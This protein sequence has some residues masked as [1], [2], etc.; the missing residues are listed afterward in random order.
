MHVEVSAFLAHQ[1]SKPLGDH[2][3]LY[4]A[5]KCTPIQAQEGPIHRAAEMTKTIHAGVPGTTTA[6]P[7]V[8][9]VCQSVVLNNDDIVKRGSYVV[10]RTPR[11]PS[12]TREQVPLAPA[13]EVGHVEEILADHEHG[14]LVGVLIT[15]CTVGHEVLPYRLPS[16]KPRLDQRGQAERRFV[17]TL[18]VRVYRRIHLVKHDSQGYIGPACLYQHNP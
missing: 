6:I 17:R 1:P 11:A 10:V 4:E 16:C 18:N 7:P 13:H 15:C 14:T 5:G 12:T 8:V 2:N 9:T 3:S